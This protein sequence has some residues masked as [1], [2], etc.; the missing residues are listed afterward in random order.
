MPRK[1]KKMKPCD[2]I[3]FKDPN[4]KEIRTATII[5]IGT[6]S[7]KIIVREGNSIYALPKNIEVI[8]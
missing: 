6:R 4:T 5:S 3:K 2:Q 8:K 7:N 1:R